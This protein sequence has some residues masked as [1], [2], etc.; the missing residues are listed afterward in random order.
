MGS[1]LSLA[2]KCVFHERTTR[3]ATLVSL[4][5]RQMLFMACEIPRRRFDALNSRFTR[6]KNGNC[7][8]ETVRRDARTLLH[9]TSS[10]S[11]PMGRELGKLDVLFETSMHGEP[12]GYAVLYYCLC[13]FGP[14][15]NGL[16]CQNMT[17]IDRS[18]EKIVAAWFKRKV[19]GILRTHYPSFT[20]ENLRQSIALVRMPNIIGLR[21]YQRDSVQKN[22]PPTR[23]HGCSSNHRCYRHRRCPFHISLFDSLTG[24]SCLFPWGFRDRDTTDRLGGVRR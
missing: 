12:F 20:G 16:L 8:L 5:S 10:R 14:Q 9:L 22:T 1:S 2:R 7:G 19:E 17:T 6:V 4:Y 13:N 24:R 15:N 11:F 18:R 23:I 3:R 21:D